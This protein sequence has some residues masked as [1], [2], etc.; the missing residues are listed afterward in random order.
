MHFIPKTNY[1]GRWR[2]FKGAVVNYFYVCQMLG[3][4]TSVTGNFVL[5]IV[6]GGAMEIKFHLI[7]L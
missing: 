3:V 4:I 6:N 7:H 1:R 2:R 5:G